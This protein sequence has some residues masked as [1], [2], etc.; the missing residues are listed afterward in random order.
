MAP[1]EQASFFACR[2]G[3]FRFPPSAQSI[4]K[5]TKPPT[6]LD[7]HP[8]VVTVKQQTTYVLLVFYSYTPGS[9]DA[10]LPPSSPLLALFPAHCAREK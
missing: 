6:T 1:S 9:L 10:K 2:P 8:S 5:K 4:H 7:A 3:L